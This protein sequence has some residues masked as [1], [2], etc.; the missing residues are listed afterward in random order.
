[1]VR[2]SWGE[3]GPH[4]ACQCRLGSEETEA[5]DGLIGDKLVLQVEEWRFSIIFRVF[6]AINETMKAGAPVVAVGTGDVVGFLSNKSS[7]E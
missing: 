1:M 6:G 3:Y 5:Q 2:G 4:V 7:A